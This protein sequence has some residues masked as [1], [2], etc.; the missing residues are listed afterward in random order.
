[1]GV[2]LASNA[3]ARSVERLAQSDSRL[4]ARIANFDV[5][6]L[7]LNTPAGVVDLKTGQLLPRRCHDLFTKSTAVA[8]GGDCPQWE[9]FLLQ[10][11]RGDREMVRYLKRFIGYTLTGITKEHAFVFLRG[12]G[13]NGKSVLLSTIAAVLG[14]YATTAMSDVVTVGRSDHHPTHLASL[15]GARMILVTETES[16]K[17]WAESRL[18]AFVAGDR[19][20]ARVMKGNP[21]EFQPIG[22]WW[23]A[24][25]H[26]PPLRNADPAMRRRMH[27]IPLTFVPQNPDPDL[28]AR[29]QAECG[30]ILAWAIRGCLEWQKEGLR[31]PSTVVNA[32]EEY[33]AEQDSVATWISERCKRTDHSFLPVR[34]AY[35]DW[36]AWA[37]ARGE[38]PGTEKW[39]SETMG[40]SLEKKRTNSGQVFLGIQLSFNAPTAEI[41]R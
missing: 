20:S 30:G 5:D 9:Q 11:N 21:F 31:P 22:K 7:I 10:I 35:E 18:K 16:G 33:F 15:R 2:R 32:S 28:A 24:G 40:H 4:A 25:N 34:R 13:M 8:P 38:A 17:P 36:K 39:F 14:D 37:V 19:I 41:E 23:V 3:T 29:L 26:S 1:M 27:L 12:P 6:P